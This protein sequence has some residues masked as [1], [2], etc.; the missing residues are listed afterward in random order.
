LDP[1]RQD[2]LV[3]LNIQNPESVDFGLAREERTQKQSIVGPVF[4]VVKS[5]ILWRR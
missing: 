4:N 5:R 3:S 2:D 1:E